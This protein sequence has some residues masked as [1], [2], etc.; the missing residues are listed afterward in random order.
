MVWPHKEARSRL[1]RKKDYV[2]GMSTTWEKKAMKT[3]AD[4]DG[5]F[6]PIYESHRNDE[7]RG[8]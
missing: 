2:D 5:L 1:R 3:K 4:M 8:P 6:Q 7:R